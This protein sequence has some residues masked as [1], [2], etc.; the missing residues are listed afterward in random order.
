MDRESHPEIGTLPL[1]DAEI[2]LKRADTRTHR[3]RA[4]PDG[5]VVDI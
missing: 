4:D 2:V 3:V 5:E 1:D